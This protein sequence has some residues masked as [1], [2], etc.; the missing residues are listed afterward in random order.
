[1]NA[2]SIQSNFSSSIG[3]TV[4]HEPWNL[5]L[6]PSTDTDPA[7]F[8]SNTYSPLSS[9]FLAHRIQLSN[10]SNYLY[11]CSYIL[12]S[13]PSYLNFPAVI[14]AVISSSLYCLQSYRKS[15]WEFSVSYPIIVYFSRALVTCDCTHNTR[16]YFE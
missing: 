1:M 5:L 15:S 16:R 2:L 6:L 13:Y 8:A 7:N 4:H 11:F 14:T 10:G 9:D 3:A 12:Q